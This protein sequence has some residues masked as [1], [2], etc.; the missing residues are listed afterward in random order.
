MVVREEDI[1]LFY[2]FRPRDLIVELNGYCFLPPCRIFS[3]I[4]ATDCVLRLR[5]LRYAG[6]RWIVTY[7]G[8]IDVHD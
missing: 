2:R 7:W 5:K 1:P 8:E 4:D 3:N 6:T